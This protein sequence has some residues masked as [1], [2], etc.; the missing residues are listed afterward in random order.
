[1]P[2]GAVAAALSPRPA[3]QPPLR[4]SRA[5]GGPERP[6][7]VVGGVRLALLGRELVE[8]VP[9]R[10]DPDDRE[11]RP[12]GRP[13]SGTSTAPRTRRCSPG[14][15]DSGFGWIET[16]G[17][18]SDRATPATVR[19]C[20]ELLNTAIA[21]AIFCS[22]PIGTA[23][24]CRGSRV[25]SRSRRRAARR[26]SAGTGAGAGAGR[27]SGG[28]SYSASFRVSGGSLAG[29]RRRRRRLRNDPRRFELAWLSSYSGTVPSRSQPSLSA[30]DLHSSH[31]ERRTPPSM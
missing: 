14:S 25:L 12:R 3:V 4:A 16:S 26:G 1:M 6:V 18:P 23:R 31:T 27:G 17:A 29:S 24:T 9:L 20:S 2:G 10:R 7:L 22:A 8:L 28:G 5:S 13:R 30:R 11:P 19:R 15:N 21:E